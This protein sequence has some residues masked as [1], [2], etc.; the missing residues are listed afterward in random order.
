MSKFLS[1]VTLFSLFLATCKSQRNIVSRKTKEEF[2]KWIIEQQPEKKIDKKLVTISLQRFFKLKGDLELSKNDSI[3]IAEQIHS[4]SESH[5]DVN[6]SPNKIIISDVA[7]ENDYLRVSNPIFFD[8]GKK[9]WIYIWHICPD[10]CQNENVEIYE[11]DKEK[12]KRL[13]GTIIYQREE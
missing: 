11:I 6:I 5:L 10:D 12:Y 4:N 8:K 1:I 7:K 3:K 13:S 2:L 9:V